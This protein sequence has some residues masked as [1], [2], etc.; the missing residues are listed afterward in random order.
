[1]VC[2]VDHRLALSNG[3]T[4]FTLL[5]VPQLE[6]LRIGGLWQSLSSRD[7]P[8]SANDPEAELFE[9]CD[10][11]KVF[12][13]NF[14]TSHFTQARA[15]AMASY[16]LKQVISSF[17]CLSFSAVNLIR[18]EARRATLLSFSTHNRSL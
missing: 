13:L 17:E 12:G 18:G 7:S 5:G 2:T 6:T 3:P 16:E 10:P 14:L 11:Y 9:N 1:M 8:R 4:Q 15:L